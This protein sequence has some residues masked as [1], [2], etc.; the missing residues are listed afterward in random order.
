M[1]RCRSWH[2][3]IDRIA[4]RK[5]LW[6]CTVFQP[7][8]CLGDDPIRG[9]CYAGPRTGGGTSS[10]GRKNCAGTRLRRR[11]AILFHVDCRRRQTLEL[12]NDP[13]GGFSWNFRS[14][15][16]SKSS[17]TPCPIK[18]QSTTPNID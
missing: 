15:I 1:E 13:E 2:D 16:F 10:R 6:W 5:P 3:R 7:D 11:V 14:P 8:W 4:S 9:S 17:S 18:R 12:V